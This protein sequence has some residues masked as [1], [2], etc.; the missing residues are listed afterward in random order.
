M[1][2]Y[3]QID[4]VIFSLGPLAIRWYS[5]AYIAGI[6][7]GILLVRKLSA[8]APKLS[9]KLLDDLLI[10]AVVGIILGGRLGYVLF[11]NAGYYLDHPLQALA[12]W[13]GGMSFHGGLLGVI[14]AMWLLARKHH[15]PFLVITD[16]LAVATPI[17]L[18][19][20]RIANFIN[21][22]LLGRVTDVPWGL[23]L[24]GE[25]VARHPSQLYQ[26]ATEGLLLFAILLLA[27]THTTIRQSMG[28][29]S[30]LF[31]F[32]YGLFRF[33]T[34]FFRSPDVQIGLYAGLWTQG[35][36]LCL[37]MIALGLFLLLRPKKAIPDGC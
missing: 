12:V 37:P 24:P 34:E 22:E 19:F 9:T 35:Q 25:L 28:R 23:V 17:G 26:A 36:L 29:L 31:L 27:A 16:Y 3:P 5:L 14:L 18:F 33:G 11:Y 20:G 30:G 10:Y 13:Q 4:P 21:G 1:I 32:C 2:P 8:T 15:T 7:L 6:L